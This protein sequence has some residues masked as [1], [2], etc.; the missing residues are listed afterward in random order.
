MKPQR[1]QL[2]IE[3]LLRD[4]LIDAI[5]QHGGNIAHTAIAL[6]APERSLRLWIARMGL[7][8]AIDRIREQAK[9]A[10]S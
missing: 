9:R 5:T 7:Q 10:D 8:P 1:R 2:W 3:S 4:P 6:E